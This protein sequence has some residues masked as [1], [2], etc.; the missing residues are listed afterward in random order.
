MDGH[1]YPSLATLV[2]NSLKMKSHTFLDV[3][4]YFALLSLSLYHL[5]NKS[6]SCTIQQSN[7]KLNSVTWKLQPSLLAHIFA[8]LTFLVSKNDQQLSHG[9]SLAMSFNFFQS[10]SK[11]PF[12]NFVTL[13]IYWLSCRTWIHHLGSSV[14]GKMTMIF[15]LQFSTVSL[16]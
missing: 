10:C 5:F 4:L 16:S 15:Y 2:T 7:P 11:F 12:K 13:I 6:F 14:I 9:H 1:Q 8:L 3:P